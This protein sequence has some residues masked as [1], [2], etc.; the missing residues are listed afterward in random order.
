MTTNKDQSKYPYDRLE[1]VAMPPFRKAEDG[2]LMTEPQNVDGFNIDKEQNAITAI[3]DHLASAGYLSAP[4]P[5]IDGLEE[6]L[7]KYEYIADQ[8][9][10]ELSFEQEWYP[11]DEFKMRSVV[12][13]ARAYLKYMED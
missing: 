7:T 12:R 8:E 13:A 5:K 6:A 9:D 4:L 2:T 10:W 1:Y 3:A 11:V